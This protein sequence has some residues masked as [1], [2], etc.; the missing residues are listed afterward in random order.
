MLLHSIP[1]R[2]YTGPLGSNPLTC[3]AMG[4]SPLHYASIYDHPSIARALIAAGA[5]ATVADSTGLTPVEYSTSPAMSKLLH[6]WNGPP[7]VWLAAQTGDMQALALA[8]GAS[9][10]I[11]A[12]IAS[13]GIDSRSPHGHTGL[14][15]A[16]V[17][18]KEKAAK[19]LLDQGAAPNFPN[20]DMWTPLHLACVQG[21]YSIATMLLDAGADP[22]SR[23]RSNLS[24][25]QRLSRQLD[26]LAKLKATA[27][28]RV[29]FSSSSGGGGGGGGGGG[30]ANPPS[31]GAPAVTSITATVSAQYTNRIDALL[32][33]LKDVQKVLLGQVPL[34]VFN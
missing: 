14:Q 32:D 28:L 15:L 25:V 18:C 27:E 10:T 9:N 16:C 23:D 4:R 17:L 26:E 34:P 19:F 2:A 31:G 8:V 24:V 33:R 11:N 5:D 6:A 30:S 3:A 29:D 7:P 22:E 20:A 13:A 1:S 12:G 21:H